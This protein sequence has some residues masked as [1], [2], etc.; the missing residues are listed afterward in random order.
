MALG[1]LLACSA[2]INRPIFVFFNFSR[3]FS[4]SQLPIGQADHFEADILL[5]LGVLHMNRPIIFWIFWL[6]TTLEANFYE[7]LLPSWPLCPIG[8]PL[9]PNSVPKRVLEFQ[10]TWIPAEVWPFLPLKFI[11]ISRFFRCQGRNS[12]CKLGQKLGMVRARIQVKKR[13][14][15]G[16][17]VSPHI[18]RSSSE[19]VSFSQITLWLSITGIGTE[20][21]WASL[22]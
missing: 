5:W 3:C 12:K 16:I 9:V 1:Y 4:P 10:T 15:A 6:R 22:V 8:N 7:L 17:R 20:F 19:I 11:K 14:L 18:H 2:V 13:F 21:R